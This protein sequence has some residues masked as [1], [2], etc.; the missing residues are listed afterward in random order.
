MNLT[1][2]EQKFCEKWLCFWTTLAS[3]LTSGKFGEKELLQFM[4]YELHTRRRKRVLNR[5]IGRYYR[6]VRKRKMVEVERKLEEC[7]NADTRDCYRGVS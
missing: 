7:E 3:Q 6:L 2:E 1:D 4:D 5:L